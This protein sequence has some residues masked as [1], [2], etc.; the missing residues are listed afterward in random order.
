MVLTLEQRV[1]LAPRRLAHP[2]ARLGLE[3]VDV[4]LRYGLG[5]DNQVRP[6]G[7]PDVAFTGGVANN[8]G[9]RKILEEK[10]G[11]PLL[12]P[13]IPQSTGALGAAYLARAAYK[14]SESEEGEIASGNR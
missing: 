8:L 14:N 12:I 11:V 7:A 4:G 6:E 9:I 10:L 1:A 13:E 3:Q 5:P 2:I